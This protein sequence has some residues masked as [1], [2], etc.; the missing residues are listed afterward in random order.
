MFSV[1][2]LC[3]AARQLQRNQAIE[4]LPSLVWY[5]I[6]VVP[7]MLTHAGFSDDFLRA[8]AQGIFIT[9]SALLVADAN[10][11]IKKRQLAP[12][13][14][15]A[16]QTCIFAYTGLAVLLALQGY[17]LAKMPRIPML[18]SIL[19][20]GISEMELKVMRE[21][22]SKLLP[23]SPIFIYAFEISL[24]ILAPL[25][26]VAF[27]Q[28]RRYVIAA[29]VLG[30]ELL[31][32][33]ATLAKGPCLI[34]I[35]SIILLCY[36]M[37][38]LVWRKIANIAASVILLAL[39]V[40]VVWILRIH[41]MSP[42]SY[43]PLPQEIPKISR[44]SPFTLSDKFRLNDYNNIL[45]TKLSDFERVL[46]STVVYRSIL[47][48]VDVS[49]RWYIFYPEVYGSYLG[50]GDLIPGA[51]SAPNFMHP[52]N[53]VGLW[54]YRDRFPD[55]YAPSVHAYA[56]ADADAHARFGFAGFLWLAA[57]IISLRRLSYY[58]RFAG[59]FGDS[60]HIMLIGLF[61]AII[62]NGSI[63]ALLVSSGGI[64]L[65]AVPL[66]IHILSRMNNSPH[67][68]VNNGA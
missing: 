32:S 53:R 55:K 60:F 5:L 14:F 47:T 22:S 6:I 40:V 26:I 52:S 49:H 28:Q 61:V 43:R 18:E 4:I 48:P 24:R 37:L 10:G 51:R 39:G 16:G 67:Q 31:Y 30:I 20:S 23:I 41:S 68:V 27:M 13:P 29:V 54:A 35:L 8:H 1:V 15:S 12:S 21:Y 36:G 66:V 57:I 46:F 65:I 64:L 11:I 2:F 45:N 38:P 59:F 3:V 44:T 62:S 25:V 42:V 7:F 34:L 63:Q 58:L 19:H 9:A 56:S 17:H 33:F 50:I